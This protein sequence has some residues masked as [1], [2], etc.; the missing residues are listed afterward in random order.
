MVSTTGMEMPTQN[1]DSEKFLT[2]E[3]AKTW[4][5]SR[6]LNQSEVAQW[7]GIT[8]QAVSKQER[9]GVSKIIALAFAAIDRGLP[10]FRPTEVDYEEAK[11]G[12]Q[13]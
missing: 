11:K 4:R 10:P 12:K 2:G 6:G 9:R 7:L 1:S 3:E 13:R 8:P 5:V